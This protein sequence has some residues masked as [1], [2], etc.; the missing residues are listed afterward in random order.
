MKVNI[1]DKIDKK[2]AEAICECMEIARLYKFEIYL[3]GGIVRD[4]LLKKR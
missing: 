2:T 1:L 4:I 3:V